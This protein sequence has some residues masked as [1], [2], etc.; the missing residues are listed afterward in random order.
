MPAYDRAGHG[1]GFSVDFYGLEEKCVIA[2]REL[3]KAEL[4]ALAVPTRSLGPR[5]K[6]R[7]K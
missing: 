5:E 4:P 1:I 3:L 6:V 7:K 2:L